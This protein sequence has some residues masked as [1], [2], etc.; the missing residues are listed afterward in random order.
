[1][2]GGMRHTAVLLLGF[3]PLALVMAFGDTQTVDTPTPEVGG[4]QAHP[5]NP[6]PPSDQREAGALPPDYQA[7]RKPGA[8]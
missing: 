3:V 1:M 5:G 6:L 2:L 4:H 8:L 7:Q